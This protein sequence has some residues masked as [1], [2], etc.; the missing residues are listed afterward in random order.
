MNFRSE[1][2]KIK[3]TGFLPAFIAGGFLAGAVPVLNMLFRSANYIKPDV[4]PVEVLFMANWQTM[5]LLNILLVL[6]GACILYHTEYTDNAM[7]R[8]RTLP[9]NESGLF[10]N[11]FLLVLMMCTILVA[12]EAAAIGFC[13]E[14]WFGGTV[15]HGAAGY[16]HICI[17]ILESLGYSLLLVLPAAL[18]SLFIASIC[19]NMWVSLGIGVLCI[20]TATMLPADN[21]VLSLFP[22]AM[23]FQILAGTAPDTVYNFITACIAEIIIILLAEMLFLKARRSFE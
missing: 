10:I 15:I 3:R 8:M 12:I 16:M 22:F 6:E 9:F 14:H 18:L 11:K 23:P 17:E 19:K 7:Q 20:F 5:A 13:C 4:N 1:C 2:I 21:F